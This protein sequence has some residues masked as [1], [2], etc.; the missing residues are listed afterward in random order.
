MTR[1]ERHTA[2]A[3][4]RDAEQL[5]ALCAVIAA[6]DPGATASS[7]RAAVEKAAPG[8]GARTR[9]LA[10]LRSDPS[11]LTTGSSQATSAT[12][13]P[14]IVLTCRNCRRDMENLLLTVSFPFFLTVL[15]HCSSGLLFR[16]DLR[17]LPANAG[18]R[19]NIT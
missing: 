11:L 15:P 2:A 4:R 19:P 3:A 1:R 18:H 16:I 10:Q 6:A 8:R 12:E 9:L 7:G 17:V 5:A 14:I 13:T